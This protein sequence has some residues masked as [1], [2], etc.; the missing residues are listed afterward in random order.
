MPQLGDRRV[1][2]ARLPGAAHPPLVS[3]AS[4][5]RWDT[6][7]TWLPRLPKPEI[8]PA[9]VQ[10]AHVE[11]ARDV[12]AGVQHT[13]PGRR[14]CPVSESVHHRTRGLVQA[15]H[16][17]RVGDARAA[18]AAGVGRSPTTA[19]RSK[20]VAKASGSAGMSMIEMLMGPALRRER[21][22]SAELVDPGAGDGD[23]RMSTDTS[24]GTILRHRNSADSGGRDVDRRNVDGYDY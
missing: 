22:S 4:S 20:A 15:G 17:R 23:R 7:D 2:D 18:T 12:D 8:T 19:A 16:S 10:R 21:R 14:H 1:D 6:P 13:G 3:I 5:H 9:R 24:I 11:H